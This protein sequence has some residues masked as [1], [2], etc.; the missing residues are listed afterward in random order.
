MK[1]SCDLYL[2]TEDLKAAKSHTVFLYRH[3][4]SEVTNDYGNL[5][6]SQ[7]GH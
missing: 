2:T 3:T 4:F 6:G 5:S 1:F 7:L